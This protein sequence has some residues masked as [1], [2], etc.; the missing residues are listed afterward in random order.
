MRPHHKL[1]VAA[2]CIVFIILLTSQ[3]ASCGNR[4][5]GKGGSIVLPPEQ[6]VVVVDNDVQKPIDHTTEET[7]VGIPAKV[8][9]RDDATGITRVV[10]GALIHEFRMQLHFDPFNHTDDLMQ[11]S[12]HLTI[13]THDDDR[14]VWEMLPSPD[15]GND[16]Q[17][18]Y[19][20]QEML[21]YLEDA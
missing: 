18:E 13:Y 1:L 15:D 10:S 21:Q 12:G 9:I 7:T 14:D 20:L 11:I 17:I 5:N 6:R 8:T 4:D 16:Y 2:A 3:P 19:T